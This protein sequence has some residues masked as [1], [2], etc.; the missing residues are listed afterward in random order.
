[1]S[2][3]KKMKVMSLTDRVRFKEIRNE[4]E[5]F[6]KEI[7]CDLIDVVSRQ[8]NGEW[9]DI[10]CDDE[11]LLRPNFISA[12][13]KEGKPELVG[14]LIICKYGG[15]GDFTGLEPDDIL[16]L[17]NAVQYSVQNGKLQPVIVLE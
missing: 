1:M 15:K 6:Y 13:N 16:R 9:Y 5:A 7:G 11:G 17:T 14:G 3:A 2:K 12:V 8:I 10:I 4:L